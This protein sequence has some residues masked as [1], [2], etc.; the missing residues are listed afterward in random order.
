MRR[1]TPEVRLR[2][3]R[4]IRK[5]DTRPE[6]AVRRIV[7]GLG[8]RYRLHV[9]GLPGNPD[10]VLPRWRKIIQVHGCFWH[11]HTGCRLARLPRSRPEYWIP[12]LARNQERDALS[13]RALE[14]LGWSVLVIWECQTESTAQLTRTLAAFLD[15]QPTARRVAA[16]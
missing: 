2:V 4:S 12:K 15:G 14:A 5:T 7:H 6:M 1:L 13:V 16:L 8:F 11:Q 3:M 9:R 10:I